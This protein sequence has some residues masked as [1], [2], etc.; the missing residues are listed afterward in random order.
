MN[1][2]FITVHLCV[3]FRFWEFHGMWILK[4][5]E[6]TW[7]NLG[8]WKTVL[9]WRLVFSFF[10]DSCFC[11]QKAKKVY[12]SLMSIMSSLL[13]DFTCLMFFLLRNP[14]PRTKKTKKT[15]W[16]LVHKF[17]FMLEKILFCCGGN[18]CENL[19]S[20]KLRYF[21]KEYNIVSQFCNIC[22]IKLFT[23]LLVIVSIFMPLDMFL[24]I[25]FILI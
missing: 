10:F 17:Y 16:S 15:Y 22:V 14:D 8:N 11:N 2:Y 12:F 19:D 7:A 21:V 24:V 18:L 4:D 20:L 3:N 13:L 9:W 5:W 6:N 1:F 23:L 25:L